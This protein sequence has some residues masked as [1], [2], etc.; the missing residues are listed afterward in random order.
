MMDTTSRT[1]YNPIQ[2]DQVIFLKTAADT[3]GECTLV[4]VD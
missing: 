1:I 3:D 2:K 4:E